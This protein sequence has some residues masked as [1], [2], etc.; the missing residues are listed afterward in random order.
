MIA[1]AERSLTVGIGGSRQA[2]QTSV[3]V[4]VDLLTLKVVDWYKLK[5]C[6]NTGF[7]WT[8]LTM[9]IYLITKDEKE[10]CE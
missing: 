1:E 2:R 8:E 5:Y 3:S 4:T 7:E 6:S 9:R 10:N